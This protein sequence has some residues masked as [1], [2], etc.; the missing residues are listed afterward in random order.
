MTT[1]VIVQARM[2]SSR[3]P[4]KILE[5]LDGKTVLD[6]VLS[7]VQRINGVD[8]VVVACPKGDASAP[9]REACRAARVLCF[10]GSEHDVLSRY[11]EAAK[12]HGR[13]EVIM[14]VTSDCPFLNPLIAGEVIQRLKDGQMD[15][16]SNVYPRR[17]YPKGFDC[18]AFTFDCLEAAHISATT[19]YEREHVT[20]WMQKTDGLIIGN[21]VQDEDMSD[22]N[23][24]VD[25]P[26]DIDRLEKMLYRGEIP[27]LKA[28]V[29]ERD[30]TRH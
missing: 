5:L 11:Y 7:R 22:I 20:P 24:C 29:K 8:M 27:M 15:Y 21:M 19:D 13:P 28:I 26:G 25:Y 10:G 30:A 16:A 12:K 14:R 9:I 23:L 1:A 18:E 4:G 6:H 3:F 2:T 17:T